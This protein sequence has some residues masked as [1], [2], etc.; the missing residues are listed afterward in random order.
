MASPATNQ[1][2]QPTTSRKRRHAASNASRAISVLIADA[3][4]DGRQILPRPL[5]QARGAW[6]K[7][8]SFAESSADE[9]SP[10][11]TENSSTNSESSDENSGVATAETTAV[12][13]ADPIE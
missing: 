12:L 6:H 9:S 4:N 2:Q 5:L 8:N 13:S 3:S 11:P 1:S 10:A 7:T